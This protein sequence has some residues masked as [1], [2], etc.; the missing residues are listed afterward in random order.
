M[1]LNNNS[2]IISEEDIILSD[3]ESTLSDNLS[4][5]KNDI[6]KLKSNV[7]WIYKYGGV[8]SKSNG[9]G[10]TTTKEFSL[11]ATL[12]DIQM[13][14]QNIV[15]N[16]TGNYRLLVQIN[17]PNGGK[18]NVTYK[19]TTK[20]SS[21]ASIEQSRTQILSIENRYR[22]DTTLLLNNNSQIVITAT[23]GESTQQVT[24]NYIT[25]PY[26]FD[27]SFVD[28]ND[29]EYE[30][31]GSLHEIFIE[32]ANRKGLNVKVKYNINITASVTYQYSFMGVQQTGT[33]ED[34]NSSITFPVSKDLFTESNAGLYSAIFNVDII[35]EGQDKIQIENNLQLSLIPYNLYCLISTDIGTIYNQHKDSNYYLFNPG[36][37]TFYYRVYQGSNEGRSYN[38]N[39][40][41]NGEQIEQ[42]SVTERQQNSF[43]TLAI[44]DGENTI[45][46]KVY[47]TTTY[48][49][50]YYFY[51]K[52]QDLT[53]DWFV[54]PSQWTQYYYRVTDCSDLFKKYKNNLYIQQTSNSDDI[55]IDGLEPPSVAADGNINTHIAIGMQYNY[56]N[57]D[58]PVIINLYNNSDDPIIQVNQKTVSKGGVQVQCY[59]KKQE[60]C[61]KDDI[62]KY[63]LLQ[64]YSRYIR[65]IGNMFYYDISLYIDGVLEASFPQLQESPLIARQIQIC[66]VNAFINT[67]DVDYK[68][69]DTPNENCDFDVYQYY[70]K[71]KSYIL[72]EDVTNEILLKDSLQDFEVCTNGR[73]KT[74]YATINN[75]A[76]RISTPVLLM[77]YQNPD[78]SIDF[79]DKIEMNYGED[80]TGAGSD[81]NFPV[82]IQWS[83]GSS[84]LNNIQ[85]PDGYDSAQFR[86][87]LQGSSTK[88]YRVKNF[89]LSIENTDE[90]EQSD[91]YLYSP[92][93][94]NNDSDTFLPETQFT[95]KADV[96]DSSH[97]N[98]TSCGKFINTVCRK[99]SED[100]SEDSVYK[101]YIKNCLEGFPFLM[102]INIVTVDPL[103][104]DRIEQ[105]YYI[106]VYNFNL[107]RQS[108]F[109]LGYKELS[110]FGD[111]GVLKNAGQEFTFFKI[112]QDKNSIREGLGVAEIQGGSNY[113]D[114][115]QYDP[116]I[117]FQQDLVGSQQD[118]TYMFGDLVHG[119]NFT[120]IQLQNK[121]QE[122]TKYISLGGGY[123]F[124]YLK[125]NKGS[126]DDGYHAEKYENGV[127]TGESLNQVPDYT[128]QYK[129]V[130]NSS[131]QW[132]YQL[133][134]E[135]Q[136]SGTIQDLRELCI[137]DIDNNKPSK[138]NYQSISEYYTICMVLGLVDSVMKNLNIKTWSGTN[139]N[140]TTW[141][142]AF[143]DMDT[144]LGINNKGGQ[145]N[146]FAFSDYWNSK[147][148]KTE[149][150]IDYPTNALVYRDFSPASLGDNGFDVPSSYLFAVAKYARLAFL[151]DNQYTIYFP[152]ELYA[153]WRSNTINSE[154]NE[155]VLKNA[156]YFIDNFYSNNLGSVNNLLIS[157]NYRSKYLSLGNDD[158]STSWITTDYEKFNGTRINQVRDWM[159]GRLH[160]LDVYF[161]LNTNINNSLQYL[162]DDQWLPLTQ[163]G[164]NVMD[165]QYNS[166]NYSVQNNTDVVVLRDI[167]SS[168][169]SSAGIQLSGN[170]D[171]KIK[172]PEYS[173]LQIYTANTS[174]YN[175]IL[176]GDNIQDINFQTTGVQSVK[177]GG[178]QA[179]TYL[180][181]INWIE[182]KNSTLSIT[183]NKLENIYG[184]KSSFQGISLQ[185]PNVKTIQL[186]SSGYQGTLNL[187]SSDNYPNLNSID[188]KGSKISLN[189]NKLNV[190]KIDASNI[191][192]S[193]ATIKISNC[194]NIKSFSVANSRLNTLRWDS[195]Q[196][197]YK[198]ITFLNNTNISNFNLSCIQSGGSITISGD[199]T[200]QNIQL[201]GFESIRIS[202]CPNLKNVTLSEYN[203]IKI[204]HVYITSCSNNNLKISTKD[205][206][207]NGVIDLS[208]LTQLY[209]INFSGDTGIN[210]VILPNNIR[211]SNGC[212]SGLAQLQYVDCDDLYLGTQTFLNCKKYEGRKSNGQYTGFKISGSNISYAFYNTNVD[213]EFVKHFYNDV[214]SSTNNITN[215][216]YLF[217]KCSNIIYGIGQYKEDYQNDSFIDPSKLS[218]VTEASNLYSYTGITVNFKQLYNF[219]SKS[220]CSYSSLIN[221]KEGYIETDCFQY[222]ISKM[223]SWGGDYNTDY[224]I[225]T[226]IQ[227][228]EIVAEGT[229]IS[230]KDIWNPGGVSPSKLQSIK[231]FNISNKYT[232][233]MSD[234]FTSSWTSFKTL[235][236]SFIYCKCINVD[237]LL[238]NVNISSIVDCFCN[239]LDKT[240]KPDLF[241]F[242]NWQKFVDNGG[243]FSTSQYRHTQGYYNFNRYI[244]YDD[245]NKL[246]NIFLNSSSKDI[247]NL[248]YNTG[249]IGYQ[250]DFQF[251]DQNIKNENIIYMRHTFDGAY[252]SESPQSSTKISLPLSQN[253]FINL[254]NIQDVRY[255]FANSK[256]S[257]PIS[258]D[259]FGKRYNYGQ[260]QSIFVKVG[261]LYKEATLNLYKY[262]QDIWNFSY[263]FYN[264]QFDAGYTQFNKDNYNIK[265]NSVVDEDGNE[266]QEYYTRTI[267]SDGEYFYKKNKL[268]DSV[269]VLDMDNLV[270]GYTSVVNIGYSYS[271]PPLGNNSKDNLIIPPDLFYCAAQTHTED[272][273][274]KGLTSYDYS[275]YC[276]AGN[277]VGIIPQNIFQAN[278]SGSVKGVF[279]N[280]VVIPRLISSNDITNVYVQYP[281]Q[282]TSYT[283][284][285]DAFTSY[286]IVLQNDTKSDGSEIVNYSLVLTTKSIP[287]SVTSMKQAFNNNFSIYG[288]T[289]ENYGSNYEFNIIADVDDTNVSFGFNMNTFN[290]MYMDQLLYTNLLCIIKGSL[291]NY[292][293]DIY[294]YRLQDIS[295][296]IIN[297]YG[298]NV[299]NH[300]SA[301]IQYPKASGNIPRFIANIQSVQIAESQ[302]ID[303]ENSKK[304]YINANISVQ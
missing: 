187:E 130:M 197:D 296:Y 44:K 106:G 244:S 115:S 140:G 174:L 117:L 38:V 292:D 149:N 133:K 80:G 46:I 78:S 77:T 242:I 121:I 272:S 175:Y 230:V 212:F 193:Q 254:P 201:S 40:L 156:D 103:T 213:F 81:L 192:N 247:S 214:V 267:N 253:F 223:K 27:L 63:H 269:E 294:N 104:Q 107:G 303:S 79:M 171:I 284:L 302:I 275:L 185:T 198:T 222:C 150:G 217:S 128:K 48:E 172:C 235:T 89:T 178:S 266:Y 108:Y 9:N 76:S 87:A 43:K 59:I 25:Q 1:R 131:G 144:C 164:S 11:Y 135:Q 288:N 145:I 180:Q 105:Y 157:Y 268:E 19:Y 109:N 293:Y 88:L 45:T 181:D 111:K 189:A 207:E 3:G 4:S 116:T 155:G 72:R 195:I 53:L 16:G 259:F 184:N 68:E 69:S 17:N 51:V 252:A 243:Y 134:E 91:V 2:K 203:D 290:Q 225:L 152:Q 148:S 249:I 196:G 120:E 248:F 158:K 277:L 112:S 60:D 33:I 124:D 57:S 52:K 205:N 147:V 64:I 100:I 165:L 84:S 119:A 98:N 274:D 93:F 129:R 177:L 246:C 50:T 257:K 285:D 138:I 218:N 260:S 291:F 71:Y 125:K 73:I 154:T 114:F 26:I 194:P 95:L 221:P 182:M 176:G 227:D 101:P 200:V 241:K 123:L 30:S 170:V 160:I 85:F 202:N 21:G 273:G 215:I 245:Y 161:N 141:Y 188:I 97:S 99:F 183:S 208:N 34:K 295:N 75:I 209:D 92:N 250:G 166:S 151:D 70:L 220:G 228:G 232:L 54:K 300:S 74:N 219:G 137:T 287:S 239:F 263:L 234:T 28:D 271:N 5:M 41:L 224:I 10:G 67:I 299:G 304:Y 262:K 56:I 20:S 211:T 6:S 94:D 236:Y 31:S 231:C 186:N 168:S 256:F 169:S 15:L 190:T 36:Y 163:G 13:K 62:S 282:Y 39:V 113:F 49:A 23:D 226:P 270:G 14:D 58:N 127:A 286:P 18:F 162:K 298:I 142:T 297:A 61:D 122:L 167:F 153:K 301:N 173:P 279:K 66:P 96:V 7:K 233:D 216:S 283:V 82:S 237:Q 32:S 159:Q 42:Q 37:I 132:I 29:A 126:Y 8:G 238:Y 281:E 204:K 206:T 191:N 251:G 280:Q 240:E 118:K 35:P 210:K 255:A 24:C 86:A 102:F 229:T 278:R 139:Q 264:S 143:Y 55:Y 83:S 12:N 199:K 289:L 136:R 261:S 22:I 265:K 90:S 179:W 47:G 146:Y 65:K 258:F 276:K 110:V